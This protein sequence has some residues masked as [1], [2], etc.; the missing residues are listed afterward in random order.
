MIK[1]FYSFI[2]LIDSKSI[3]KLFIISLT[4]SFTIQADDIT[5][6]YK[7][8]AGYLYNFTKFITW[9]TQFTTSFNVCVI[10]DIEFTEVLKPIEQHQVLE[11]PIKIHSYDNIHQI[12]RNTHCHILFINDGTVDIPSSYNTVNTL[13]VGNDSDFTAHGGMISFIITD[14]KVKLQI[15]TDAIKSSSLKVSAKLLEVAY[16]VTTARN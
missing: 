5:S 14:N 7:I 2:S 3:L 10:G 9:S 13:V 1:S 16:I 12:P 8:K 6:V 11:T 4:Y 15:N